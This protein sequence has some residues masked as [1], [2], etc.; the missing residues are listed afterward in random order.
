MLMLDLIV[1][2]PEDWNTNMQRL[3]SDLNDLLAPK[4]RERR[5]N[6]TD[7]ILGMLVQ[8]RDE[9]GR[10]LTDEQLIAHTNILLVAGHETSTSLTAWLLYLLAENP[11]YLQRVLDEQAD[12]LTGDEDPSLDAVKRMKVLDN[13]LSEAERLYPPVANGPR[14][15]V[16]AFEFNGYHV[17][18]DTF[19]MYS[20]YT[21]H[22]LPSIW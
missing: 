4:I 1:A 10:G 7:D 2:T 9:Q 6:P 19:V 12:T 20:I 22:M 17:P 18:A 5:E 13:A 3:K 11:D 14:G 8:A 21:T 15:A 16:E